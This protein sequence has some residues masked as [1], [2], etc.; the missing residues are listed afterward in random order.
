[1]SEIKAALRYAES[2]P[3]E[4]NAMIEKFELVG[5]GRYVR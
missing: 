4:I 3:E 5:T 2:H 1:M